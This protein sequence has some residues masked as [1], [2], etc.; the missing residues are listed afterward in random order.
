M[1]LLRAGFRF[2]RTPPFGCPAGTPLP[3]LSPFSRLPPFLIYPVAAPAVCL[4][5]DRAHCLC[6]W[7]PGEADRPGRVAPRGSL[8]S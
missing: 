5:A 8:N 3:S 4:G 1:G 7:A 6:S 2:C